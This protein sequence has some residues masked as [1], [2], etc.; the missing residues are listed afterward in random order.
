MISGDDESLG[1]GAKQNMRRR[2]SATATV[3]TEQSALHLSTIPPSILAR[4]DKVIE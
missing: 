1:S 3:P 2:T 4:A